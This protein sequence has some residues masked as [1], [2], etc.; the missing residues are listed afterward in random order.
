M[1]L[2]RKIKNFNL[3]N[4]GQNYIGQ[5]SEVV[6]PKLTTKMEEYRGGGMDAPIDI[7]LGMEKL[8]MEWSVGGI[9]KQVLTQYGSLTHNGVGLRFAGALQSDDLEEVKALEIVVRGRHSEIDMG[10]AKPGDDTTKKITSSL[11]YYKVTLDG[12]E[13]IEIDIPNMVKRIGGKD[14]MDPFRLALGL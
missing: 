10:T 11:S 8:S 7:D 4:E 12:E 3:F 6:L 1:S 9:I 5:V 14:L 13:I 2:P